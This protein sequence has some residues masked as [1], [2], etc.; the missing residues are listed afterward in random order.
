MPTIS[1]AP[2]GA[3][4]TPNEKRGAEHAAAGLRTGQIAGRMGMR[5]GSVSRLLSRI[6][7]KYGGGS[8]GPARTHALLTARLIDPPVPR[9]RAPDFTAADLRL[10]RAHAEHSGPDDIAAAAGLRTSQLD[11]AT[12]L[13]AATARAGNITLLVALAHPWGLLGTAEHAGDPR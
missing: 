7:D 5:P 4:L 1:S 8:S 11:Q 10:L 3:S 13:L 9:R 12:R 6:G 2:P